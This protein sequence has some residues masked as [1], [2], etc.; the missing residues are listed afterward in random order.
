M[1]S[2]DGL[3]LYGCLFKSRDDVGRSSKLEVS[4]GGG[5][6]QHVAH[7]IPLKRRCRRVRAR[8]VNMDAN[9]NRALDPQRIIH[10]LNSDIDIDD[11]RVSSR[12]D[13]PLL[14]YRDYGNSDAQLSP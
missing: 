14:A 8:R 5:T 10:I 3:W 2:T 4:L 13:V 1:A 6:W 11:E 9:N 12:V 7:L